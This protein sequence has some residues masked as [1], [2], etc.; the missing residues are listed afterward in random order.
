MPLHPLQLAEEVIEW[1][2][3]CCS[4]FRTRLAQ[5]RHLDASLCFWGEAD[6]RC[7]L[8][9][10]A[11]AAIDP[12]SDIWHLILLWRITAPWQAARAFGRWD[13][14]RCE[15]CDDLLDR[16]AAVLRCPSV[17]R[18]ASHPLSFTGFAT[19]C[20]GETFS[21]S[22]SAIRDSGSTCASRRGSA[23]RPSR[24]CVRARAAPRPVPK[25]GR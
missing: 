25:L 7:R 20:H 6:M 22:S 21:I 12:I 17:P 15:T 1:R 16:R 10:M 11:C 3:F 4:A 8:A 5:S 19:A 2:Y 18:G 14:H 9:L 23:C 24:Y 13:C